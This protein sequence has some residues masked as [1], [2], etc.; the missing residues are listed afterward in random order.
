MLKL[1]MRLFSDAGISLDIYGLPEL[2]SLE[3]K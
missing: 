1:S 2:L 3:I